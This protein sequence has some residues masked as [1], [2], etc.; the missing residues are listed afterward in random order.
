MNADGAFMDTMERTNRRV[1]PDRRRQP[2]PFISRYRLIGGRRRTVR[3]EAEQ[4][5]YAVVEWYSPQL[6]IALLSLLILS[7]L[8]S[9][10]TLTVIKYHGLTEINPVMALYLA[11]GET[12]FI[13]DKFLI[14]TVSIFIFCLC[15]SFFFT[16]LSLASSIII[17]LA[18]V[19]YELNIIHKFFIGF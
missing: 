16:K 3:R 13:I 12:S 7:S 6:L 15:S 10:F 2:T 18:V 11:S 19:S 8:D 1:A 4:G 9:Y 14:T 5:K 17:Y